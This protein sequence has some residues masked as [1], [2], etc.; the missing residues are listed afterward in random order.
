MKALMRFYL[1]PALAVGP[2]VHVLPQGPTAMA[3]LQP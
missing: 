1:P 2:R 3:I